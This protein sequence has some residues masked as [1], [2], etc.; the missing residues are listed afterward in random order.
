MNIYI[1]NLP[2]GCTESDIATLFVDLGGAETIRI[3]K[4]PTTGQSRGFAFVTLSDQSRNDEAIMMLRS[5]SLEGRQIQA[6]RV[7]PLPK[8][9]GAT[10]NEYNGGGGR[11][12]PSYQIRKR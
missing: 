3:V 4:N 8:S 5:K 10:G 12:N 11:L 9:G 6:V 2:Q 7:V 1:G